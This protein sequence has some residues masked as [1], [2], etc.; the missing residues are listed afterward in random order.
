MAQGGSGVVF[1][2]FLSHRYKSPE[3]N[4]YFFQIF[5]D[6]SA[7]PQFAVD[8]GTIATSVT[9]LERLIRGS[10]A[11]IA[12][13]PF[14]EDAEVTSERLKNESRYFRLELGLA[15]RADKPALAFIDSEFGNVIAPPRQIMQVRFNREEII[16]HGGSPRAAEFKERVDHFCKRVAAWRACRTSMSGQPPGRTSYKGGRRRRPRRRKH[17]SGSRRSFQ[18]TRSFSG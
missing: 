10:D 6:A 18:N 1:R 12:I 13:Y 3:V 5:A 16:P 7:N 11:F 8:R 14:P 17:S 2:A 15:E 4:E 9:R